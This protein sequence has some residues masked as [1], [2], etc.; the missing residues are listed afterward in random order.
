ML[1]KVFTMFEVANQLKLKLD[2]KKIKK[3]FLVNH[4]LERLK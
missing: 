3:N 2:Y 1:K 4:Y